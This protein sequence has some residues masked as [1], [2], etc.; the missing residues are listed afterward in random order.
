MG[1]N[2]GGAGGRGGG[3]G[4]LGSGE[5]RERDTRAHNLFVPHLTIFHTLHLDRRGIH[6][7]KVDDVVHSHRLELYVQQYTYLD[8]ICNIVIVQM[9]PNTHAN[10]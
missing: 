7:V 1:S 3:E 5:A 10:F 6:E 9:L 4:G 8:C 2:I